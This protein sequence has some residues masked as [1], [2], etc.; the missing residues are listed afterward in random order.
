MLHQRQPRLRLS[1]HL[2]IPTA[3]T[4]TA[5]APIPS[6][7]RGQ[8]SYLLDCKSRPAGSVCISYADGY[9]WLVYDS[10]AGWDDAGY[11]QG[12]PLT[13]SQRLQSG[14]LPHC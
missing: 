13:S 14:L 3:V 1:H 9:I 4:T 8:K 2:N 10:I 6:G 12:H 7:F 11:R 5:V